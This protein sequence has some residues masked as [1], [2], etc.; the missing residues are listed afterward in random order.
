MASPQP[1]PMSVPQ[2]GGL[3]PPP[4]LEFGAGIAIKSAKKAQGKVGGRWR[5]QIKRLSKREREET[6]RAD[7]AEK[8][9]EVKSETGGD[10]MNSATSSST[11]NRI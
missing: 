6:R 7:T 2:V 8:V 9:L 1:V 5:L 3:P 11:K 4:T 10:G